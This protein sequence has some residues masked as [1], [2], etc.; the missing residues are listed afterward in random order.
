M[1]RL[2]PCDLGDRGPLVDNVEWPLVDST[3]LICAVPLTSSRALGTS[4]G[5]QGWL[6]GWSCRE[7][8]ESVGGGVGPGLHAS[9]SPRL[10]RPPA[11]GPHGEDRVELTEREGGWWRGG[12]TEAHGN[13]MYSVWIPWRV[14][15]EVAFSSPA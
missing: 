14:R 6:G 1:G 3:L 7:E 10:H 5:T 13:Y 9:S 12:E 4:V 8:K 15:A 11:P 2:A